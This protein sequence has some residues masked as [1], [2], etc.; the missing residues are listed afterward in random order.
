MPIHVTCTA[1][2]QMVA[3][4]ESMAGKKAVCP[5]CKAVIAIPE[6]Y[7]PAQIVEPE[8]P[9]LS[10][11]SHDLGS[12][13]DIAHPPTI[14]ARTE[15]EK[16][17]L[18]A[19]RFVYL[20]FRDDWRRLPTCGHLWLAFFLFFLPW[21]NISCNGRTLATQSGFQSCRGAWTV[22]PKLEKQLRNDVNQRAKLDETPPWSMLSIIYLVFVV[23][24]GLCGLV[25]IGF[26]LLRLHTFA[27]ATHLFSLGLGSAAFL[28]LGSQ[29]AIGF[30][31]DK[32][33]RQQVEKA[34]QPRRN[35]QPG[36]QMDAWFDV[37]TK[38]TAWLWWSA[39]VSFVS[40]PIFVLEFAVLIV[41]AV[42]KHMRMQK[43]LG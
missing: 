20:F 36:M 32:H 8:P 40:A 28:A 30:P 7:V 15:E 14:D 12:S 35:L 38:Y 39:V 4:P 6:Q 18:R 2:N 33:V 10:P 24:G 9:S 27:A 1:C 29:M 37:E 25:C 41:E 3:A 43:A 42:R 5:N 21:V 17:A 31:V 13:L 11:S 23:P 34:E 22:D 16:E 26:V 19:L